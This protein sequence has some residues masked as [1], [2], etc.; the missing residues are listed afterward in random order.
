M[1]YES[2]PFLIKFIYLE[3]WKKTFLQKNNFQQL[4]EFP[5]IIFEK[6]PKVVLRSESS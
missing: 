5:P 3:H 1:H 2:S 6:Y 4:K